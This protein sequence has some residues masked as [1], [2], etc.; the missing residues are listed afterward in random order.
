MPYTDFFEDSSNVISVLNLVA[1]LGIGIF[2]FSNNQKIENL[3]SRLD[4]QSSKKKIL[5]E[6][7]KDA[8]RTFY[9]NYKKWFEEN[10]DIATYNIDE[11]TRLKELPATLEK[12]FQQS[13]SDYSDLEL[14]IEDKALLQCSSNLIV[15]TKNLEIL[16]SNCSK[17]IY[18]QFKDRFDTY[19]LWNSASAENRHNI[20]AATKSINEYYKKYYSMQYTSLLFEIIGE[21]ESFLALAKQYIRQD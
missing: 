13:L 17:V 5:F 15:H 14:F 18:G 11:V 20:Q 21:K 1:T 2:A 6:E 16:N 7:E 12:H 9:F 3:K 4:L 10:K 8:I 19:S